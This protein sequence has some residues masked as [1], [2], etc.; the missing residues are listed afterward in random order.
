MLIF[1]IEDNYLNYT[2]MI[3]ELAT[4]YTWQS[5]L[6]FDTEYRQRQAAHK[7]AWGDQ[8]PYLSTMIL[9]DHPLQTTPM[10]RQ[11]SSSRQHQQP[12]GPSSKEVCLQYNSG[13]CS[14]GSLCVFDHMCASCRKPPLPR[15]YSSNTQQQQFSTDVN[16]ANC[17]PRGRPHPLL[18]QAISS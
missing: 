4:C 13:S 14:Y 3:S 15:P 7:L 9:Q 10:Q 6:M 1:D 8:A 16:P 2:K 5:V 18:Q 17:P 11:A 12:M